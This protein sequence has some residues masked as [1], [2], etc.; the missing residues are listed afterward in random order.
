MQ[1]IKALGGGIAIQHRMAYQGESFVQRYGKNP[2]L[3]SPP[4]K[5]MLELGIP[6]GLG[7]DGT[8]V[9]SYNLW[10]ALY[11]ITTGKT[12]GGTQIMAQKNA[13]DRV[14][15]LRLATHKGYELIKEEKKGKIEQGYYADLVI[16]DKDYLTVTDEEIKNITS[17]L[18]IVDGK[19]VFASDEY[20]KM[21]P[22][23]P[24]VIPFWSP[25]KYFG[26]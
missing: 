21:N 25:V 5:R 14:T 26:G 10:M 3:A 7:T 22:K 11:W 9:A 16:L 18:T 6:V 12:V 8:R 2:A 20:K 19:V 4:V 1:R 13:L 23:L 15:A 24:E 17:K